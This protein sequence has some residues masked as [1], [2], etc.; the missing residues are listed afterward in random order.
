MVTA[1]KGMGEYLVQENFITED[2]LNQA[3]DAQK[4]SR[5][6]LGKIL[7]ELGFASERDVTRAKAQEM[8]LGFVDLTRHAPD[9]SA[10]NVVPEHI[11]KRHN[12]IPVK[13]DSATNTL[14]VAM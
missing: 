6:D 2:Q 7:I 1:R 8:S 13:K 12:V 9:P 5:G 4:A 14:Y 11:A 3:K 10:V